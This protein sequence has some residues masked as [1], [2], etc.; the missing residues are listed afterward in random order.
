MVIKP[1]SKSDIEQF[2]KLVEWGKYNNNDLK[3]YVELRLLGGGQPKQEFIAVDEIKA[4]DLWTR[5]L[6][7]REN[8]Y[9]FYIGYTLRDKEA[10][11]K[12]DCKFGNL[13]ILD[14]D[15]I[16]GKKIKELSGQ[17][18]KEAR[19]N[20]LAKIRDYD[21]QPSAVVSSG[22]G[23]HAYFKLDRPVDFNDKQIEFENKA[24]ALGRLDSDM[25]SDTALANI[26][27]PIRIP[28][29]WNT[30]DPENHLKCF[31]VDYNPEIS[32]KLSELPELKEQKTAV[33]TPVQIETDSSSESD[34]ERPYWECEI[35]RYLRNNPKQQSYNLWLLAASNLSFF[36]AEGRDAF[37]ELSEGYPDYNFEE[38]EQIFNDMLA[39]MDKGAATCDRF[40]E[41]GI[42]CPKI[43]DCRAYAPKEL[44]EN[45]YELE[46]LEKRGYEVDYQK[47][48]FNN[49]NAN[50]FVSYITERE[51]LIYYK[52]EH[53]Y[54]YKK[55]YWREL[56]E[57][58]LNKE[59]REILHEA[60][61]NIWKRRLEREYLPA[62]KR[63]VNHIDEFD[64]KNDYINLENG[65]LNIKSREL[66]DH[67]PDYYSRVQIPLEYDP[68]VDC[69]TF[70]SFLNDI[71]EGDQSRIDVI[72]EIMGYM[73]CNNLKAEKAFI[74]H[75]T[76]R[77]GK[78]TLCG[79]IR[80]LIGSDNTSA[81]PLS[82]L[83]N[84]N[85]RY[86]LIDKKA[87]ISEENELNK[88][89]T[90]FFKAIT[91]GDEILV[92]KKY[93]DPMSVKLNLKLL[94]A[95]NK[96]PYTK[97]KSLGYLRRLHIIPFDKRISEDEVDV[98]LGEKLRAELNGIL[99]FALDGLDRL[100]KND[101]KF[102]ESKAINQK[103][104]NYQGKIN[105]VSRY[106]RN[107]ISKNSKER[108]SR[109]DIK[110][111]FK[112]WCRYHGH[113]KF[114]NISGQKLWSLFR[115]C[116]EDNDIGYNE[117]KSGNYRYFSGIEMNEFERPDRGGELEI[118]IL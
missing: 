23:F 25:P 51:D 32:Y 12:K 67:Q 28:G 107:H 54:I 73:L 80:D 18:R 17:E 45:L 61:D 1:V 115:E 8:D 109:S 31:I 78:S 93:C 87:N 60:K 116:L 94:F 42:E 66:E 37:H 56:K 113:K 33:K 86:E 85:N 100:I 6:E 21:Y 101:Y 79:V 68:A 74:F 50:K 24:K 118:D 112:K 88:L 34:Y 108:E 76:G 103:L 90:T 82:E 14:F 105:P 55:G 36:G 58:A 75:G 53:W 52:G 27:Q 3:G 64:V 48:K 13:I 69:P 15:E 84:S 98:D 83:K 22:N 44:I 46:E 65:M 72:Q 26:A 16:N 29:S 91:T 77:N 39:G 57:V 49:F 43:G 111:N 19:D 106:V 5:S 2:L 110:D 114:A 47:F 20:L 40:T 71:M 92:E 99:N 104:I 59:L 96:L 4:D 38:T 97:D 11:A 89:N 63:E 10:G 41:E 81:V 9:N 7:C 30:K 35:L 95:C 117:V 102:T 70:K 62:L